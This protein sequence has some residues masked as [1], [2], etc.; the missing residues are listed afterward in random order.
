MQPI[1]PKQ[2]SAPR[3]DPRAGAVLLAAAAAAAADAQCW[4]SV[5]IRSMFDCRGKSAARTDVLSQESLIPSAECWPLDSDGASSVKC[6]I[7]SRHGHFDFHCSSCPGH[8]HWCNAVTTSNLAID[9]RLVLN[10]R[11]ICHAFR[12]GPDRRIRLGVCSCSGGGAVLYM[13]QRVST[14]VL[15][16]P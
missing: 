2:P 12:S 1:W 10:L 14:F 11:G 6:M 8:R 3:A 7:F 9:V 4:C 16:G 13:L 5:P 15:S